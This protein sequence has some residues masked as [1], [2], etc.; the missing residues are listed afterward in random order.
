MAGL[1]A[2][3]GGSLT[4]KECDHLPQRGRI[5]PPAGILEEMIVPIPMYHLEH[6]P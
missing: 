3:I 1:V 2:S 6:Y 4:L 5:V